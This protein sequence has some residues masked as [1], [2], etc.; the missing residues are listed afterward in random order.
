MNTAFPLNSAAR[1]A[2]WIYPCLVAPRFPGAPTLVE[3][4]RAHT[5]PD[6]GSLPAGSE[7]R[8]EFYG[9]AY[10]LWM[11]GNLRRVYIRRFEYVPFPSEEDARHA[12][13]TLWRE[14]EHLESAAEIERTAERW[15][16]G[17]KRKRAPATPRDSDY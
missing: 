10:S 8:V 11:D 6:F 5:R 13:L 12:F 15:M 3:T 16:E 1:N 2:V 7:V 17:W 9:G 4:T 14:V